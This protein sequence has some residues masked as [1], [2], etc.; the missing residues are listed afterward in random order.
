MSRAEQKTEAWYGIHEKED[1]DKL[2]RIGKNITSKIRGLEK[3]KMYSMKEGEICIYDD[4]NL[5]TDRK[6][7]RKYMKFIDRK[8]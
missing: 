1:I 3:L 2:E 5:T 4:K 6:H 8:S 7:K